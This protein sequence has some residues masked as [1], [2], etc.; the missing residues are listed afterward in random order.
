MVLTLGNAY[1]EQELTAL[2]QLRK[3]YGDQVAFICI[4]LDRSPAAL[5]TW[6][7][8]NPKLNWSWF[9]PVDPRR[10]MDDLRIR[11]TPVLYLLDGNRLTASP[12]PL[13]SQGLAAILY[14]IKVKDDAERRLRPDRGVPPPKR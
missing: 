4:A 1:S 5:A 12:G 6:M 7:R 14:G 10:L 11:S 3:E 8:A 9:I 2:E 13:P